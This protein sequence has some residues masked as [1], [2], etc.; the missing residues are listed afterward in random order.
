[1]FGNLPIKPLAFVSSGYH[2]SEG[3]ED[4]DQCEDAQ[5]TWEELPNSDYL[6]AVADGLGGYS[7]GFDGHTG[8]YWASRAVINAVTKF[9]RRSVDLLDR[10]QF[11]AEL[12][13]ELRE[14]L[15]TLA[16]ERL[17]PSKIKGTLA[18]HKLASTLAGAIIRHE[19]DG[20]WL[21][22]FW[23]GDSRLYLLTTAGLHQLT[24]DDVTAK[25]DAFG[26]LT[27]DS[28]MSQFLSA[29]MDGNWRIRV[30]DCRVPFD[31]LLIACT[32][33]C[34]AYWASPWEFELAIIDAFQQASGWEEWTARLRATIDCVKKDDASLAAIPLRHVQFTEI[35]D[36]LDLEHSERACRRSSR[37]AGLEYSQRK[38]TWEREYRPLYET[39]LLQLEGNPPPTLRIPVAEM[40]SSNER[41]PEFGSQPSAGGGE[42]TPALDVPPVHR[43]QPD[44]KES[45]QEHDQPFSATVPLNINDTF[46]DGTRIE[47]LVEKLVEKPD[48][49]VP[50]APIPSTAPRSPMASIDSQAEAP[51]A[52][53]FD[54]SNAVP[55]KEGSDA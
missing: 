19:T 41:G 40:R 47:K 12:T 1:M 44:Q 23:I 28:P 14:R 17:A 36:A 13:A 39:F 22:L 42:P 52:A 49:T 26:A 54:S 34:F 33:G 4:V 27:N 29:N 7:Q 2:S 9:C 37:D 16:A 8:A 32:D 51:S 21:R 11:Q 46:P 38:A 10:N 6:I 31:A 18:Q 53:P 30:V 45:G 50:R 20:A 24:S 15:T 48:R 5:P 35:R 25:S 3:V 43:S 55:K